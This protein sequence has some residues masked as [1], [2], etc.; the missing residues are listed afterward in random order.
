MLKGGVQA[1]ALGQDAQ[2]GGG[3]AVS[4]S[5]KNCRDVVLNDMVNGHSLFQLL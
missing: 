3:V 5:V 1:D 4:G 2:R